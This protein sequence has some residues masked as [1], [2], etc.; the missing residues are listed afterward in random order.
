M[1]GHSKEFIFR[2][3]NVISTDFIRT[4]LR[5]HIGT[6]RED[7]Y[8]FLYFLSELLHSKSSRYSNG[9]YKYNSNIMAIIFHVQNV[10]IYGFEII[11]P[12]IYMVIHRGENYLMEQFLKCILYKA[13]HYCSNSI[14]R[15]ITNILSSI[16]HVHNV[17]TTTGFEIIQSRMHMD[18]HRGENNSFI[19]IYKLIVERSSNRGLNSEFEYEINTLTLNSK[20]YRF[21]VQS[22]TTYDKYVFK[23]YSLA[24]VPM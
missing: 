13:H 24:Q 22:V 12:R 17:I 2:V 4:Q 19:N 14:N 3:L 9:K 10:S 5:I 6:H 23:I 21:H 15:N 8:L 7:K 11:L 20:S 16:F 1:T 18:I